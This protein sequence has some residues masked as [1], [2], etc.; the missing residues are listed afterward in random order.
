MIRAFSQ[1]Q[2]TQLG[3]RLKVGV[4]AD[5]L[6]ILDEYRRSF[7][8]ACER[9]IHT[10]KT[11][12]GLHPTA[13][14]AKSTQAIVEKLNR[15][16]SRLGQMQDIAGCRITVDSLGYQD[17]AVERLKEQ[18][19]D[20]RV[21]D[22]RLKP[23][24]GYRAVHVIVRVDDF[25][26]E[27]QIRTELQ[28]LWASLS[29]KMADT[30]GIGIKYGVG[31]PGPMGL[32]TQVANFVVWLEDEEAKLETRMLNSDRGDEAAVEHLLELRNE[33]EWARAELIAF[34]E[35]QLAFLKSDRTLT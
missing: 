12:L 2:L 24:H 27:V 26:V 16:S 10:I 14:P 31:G 35:F 28:H 6:R 21:E 30:Y 3:N 13:R 22:R 17:I 34:V 19:P 1:S 4:T 9:V 23:S 15:L 20:C 11:V 5:D 18:Y 25:W 7:G 29:E 8:P 33:H 32:L